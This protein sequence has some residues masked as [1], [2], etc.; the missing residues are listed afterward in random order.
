[1]ASKNIDELLVSVIMAVYKEPIE[2]L[3]K[4]IHSILNQTYQNI[5]FIIILDNPENNDA[6]NYINS[7]SDNRIKLFINTT[8]MGL[9]YSMNRAIENASGDY[10]ARMDADDIAYANR[11][12]LQV[13]FLE[14]NK[15]I[16]LVGSQMTVINESGNI[17]GKMNLPLNTDL[18]KIIATFVQP[19][20]H[21]TWVFRK[22]VLNYLKKY[23]AYPVDDYDFLNRMCLNNLNIT[24]LEEELLYYRRNLHGITSTKS[25]DVIILKEFMKKVYKGNETFREET[26]SNL[27]VD[28]DEETKENFLQ[29][30]VFFE[31]A[32]TKK[33]EKKYIKFFYYLFIS[34][35]LS[36]YQMFRLRN[37]VIFKV[38]QYLHK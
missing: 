19:A 28:I 1:M 36:K 26:F 17:I 6:I 22:E 35:T 11:L 10:I 27:L 4:A 23:R 3:G 21:P 37:I 7:I 31:K 8:N 24:N 15:N 30:E 34:L 25:L 32:I 18:L 12:K 5:E 16:D 20:F 14:M 38:L 13:D 29:S 2:W 33:S 9:A